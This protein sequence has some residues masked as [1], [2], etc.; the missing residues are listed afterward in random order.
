MFSHACYEFRYDVSRSI[1]NDAAAR[2]IPS[3]LKENQ[4]PSLERYNKVNLE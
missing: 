1:V 2:I 3:Q 4:L